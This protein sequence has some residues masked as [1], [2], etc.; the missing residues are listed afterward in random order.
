MATLKFVL[1]I[2]LGPEDP[3]GAIVNQVDRHINKIFQRPA[4]VLWGAHDFVFNRDYYNEWQ[5]RLPG[6]ETHW[7]DDAGHYLLEDIPDK[8]ISHIKEFLRNH[9]LK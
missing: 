1:D 5:R 9:P 8:I 4:M 7:F 3:S 6:V 2:P